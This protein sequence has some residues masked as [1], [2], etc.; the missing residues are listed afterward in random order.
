[1]VEDV[2]LGTVTQA[3]GVTGK[4]QA[5]LDVVLFAN[6]GRYDV[7]TIVALDGNSAL[8]GAQCWLESRLARWVRPGWQA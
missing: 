3:C 7:G 2:V 6:V 1:M 8:S 5:V 4:A